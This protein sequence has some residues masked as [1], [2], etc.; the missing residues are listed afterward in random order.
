MSRNVVFSGKSN[1]SAKPTLFRVL[2]LEFGS[3]SNP[4]GLSFAPKQS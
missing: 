2:K 3:K 1:S 4:T